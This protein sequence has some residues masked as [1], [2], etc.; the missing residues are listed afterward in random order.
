MQVHRDRSTIQGLFMPTRILAAM[1]AVFATIALLS[2]AA[3][4]G[5]G[6]KLGT[7]RTLSVSA[8]KFSSIQGYEKRLGLRDKEVVLTFDD[9]PL[10]STSKVLRALANE[11]VKATFFVVGRHV[12]RTP[13]KVK[14][15]HRRGHTIAHH[16]WNHENLARLS[17]AKMERAIDRGVRAVNKALYGADTSRARNPM[18]RYPYLAK[19]KRTRAMLRRKGLIEIGT[20]ID[21][22]DWKRQSPA[23]LHDRIMRQLAKKRRGIVLMHDIQPRTA[24]ML[25]RLLRSMKKSGYRIVHMVPAGRARPSGV[26]VAALEPEATPKRRKT[27]ARAEKDV[28][29]VS[30]KRS[31]K[32][33]KR[34]V[35]KRAAAKKS[36][37]KRKSRSSLK[38]T[39]K[40]T[41]A[42]A[43]KRTR[44]ASKRT[45]SKKRRA[46]KTS[47]R[48]IARRALGSRFIIN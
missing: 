42:K 19:S 31:K 11:C 24:A 26:E 27:V 12:A 13:G 41:R 37:A 6:G 1:L 21:T 22:G 35:A 17:N 30:A 29:K 9:G 3:H 8:A 15:M 36:A 18:F 43:K 38:R 44:K 48:R 45:A 10:S 33:V 47:S 34:A 39:A 2:S 23:Q 16:T 4:A 32:A 40:R 28:V 7:A 25:P 20:N 46:R 5:C 14:A